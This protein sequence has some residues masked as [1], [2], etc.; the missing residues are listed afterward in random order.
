MSSGTPSI[1]AVPVA[2]LVLFFMPMGAEFFT[3]NKSG[4]E[5]D[6]QKGADNSFEIF[7]G[8]F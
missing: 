4:K 1:V 2:L 5:T 6:H 8:D 7:H 3:S